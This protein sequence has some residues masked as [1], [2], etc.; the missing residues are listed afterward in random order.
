MRSDFYKVEHVDGTHI[1]YRPADGKLENKNKKKYAAGTGA[2]NGGNRDGKKGEG[3]PG[4][5]KKSVF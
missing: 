5:F 3:V 1:S 4:A 2:E